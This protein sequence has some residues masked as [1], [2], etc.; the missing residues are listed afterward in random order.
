[1]V[2]ADGN[3][4]M[5]NA[6]QHSDL[7]WAI[8]GGGGG[9][10]GVVTRMTLRTRELPETFGAVFG[11]IRASS[12]EAYKDLIAQAISFY[13]SALFNPHWGEQMIF[14]RENILQL[15]MVY[16]GLS[17]QQAEQIWAP[18]FDWVR[19]NKAY[20]FLS[21]PRVVSLPARH[22]WD[23][24]FL[25]QYAAPLIVADDRPGAPAKHILWAGDQGQVGWF[26]HG[27]QSAW[28]PESLLQ[29]E[30]QSALVDALFA[31]SRQWQLSLHFNKGLAGAP[32]AEIEAAKD[33][34]TNPAVLDAFAL[35][36]CAGDG[37]PA[38]SGL[39]GKGPDL[40][41]A[42]EEA[43]RIDQAAMEILSVAPR[44]G[45]YVSESNYFQRDWQSAFWGANYARLAAVKQAYD[46][47]GLF[48]VHHGVGS[49]AWSA[50]GFTRLP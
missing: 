3:V 22:F 33:T 48:F 44:A 10:V 43:A 6:C 5:V 9:S 4:N 29:D 36:I 24:K 45:A 21:E 38:Y 42:R 49:E 27:F 2:T 25:K 50:D 32:A 39:P 17:Q 13:K 14:R 40:S 47:S 8:K 18:F 20:A 12:N 31:G 11:A 28:L 26:I 23:A 34:A 19:A 30:R 7:F 41:V 16:Q 37:P 15:N 46:P 35:M 1:V